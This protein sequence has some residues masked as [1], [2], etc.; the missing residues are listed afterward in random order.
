MELT[1]EIISRCV[2]EFEECIEC[3]YE[4]FH[5][6]LC[7]HGAGLSSDDLMRRLNERANYLLAPNMNCYCGKPASGTAWIAYHNTTMLLSASPVC[8][9]HSFFEDDRPHGFVPGLITKD[10][11]K[12]QQVLTASNTACT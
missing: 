6:P 8:S 10:V 12:V 9:T 5:A 7:M 11:V 4:Y 2:N 3:G 1:Q